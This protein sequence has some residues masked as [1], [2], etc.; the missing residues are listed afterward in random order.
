MG[1]DTD[2]EIK[3]NIYKHTEKICKERDYTSNIIKSKIEEYIQITKDLGNGLIL[4]IYLN[5]SL[6][7][8]IDSKLYSDEISFKFKNKDGSLLCM[9]RFKTDD[10]YL[11]VINYCL[12]TFDN[13]VIFYDRINKIHRGDITSKDLRKYKISNI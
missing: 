3:E 7:K 6:P 4:P 1:T 5:I 11:S 12:D 8:K 2:T 10:S 13:Y 9:M